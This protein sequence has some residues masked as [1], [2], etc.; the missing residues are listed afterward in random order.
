M[1][2]KKIVENIRRNIDNYFSELEGNK[3]FSG[4]ILVSVKGEKIISKGFG[5]ANYEL[6]VPNTSNS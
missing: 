6:D 3:R 5:L 2:N 1:L 4:A